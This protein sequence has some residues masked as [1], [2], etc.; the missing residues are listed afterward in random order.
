MGSSTAVA[1]TAVTGGVATSPA[2]TV[3]GEVEAVTAADVTDDVP[4]EDDPPDEE[5]VGVGVGP[6]V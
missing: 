3:A 6:L 2:T 1:P 4:V 5:V